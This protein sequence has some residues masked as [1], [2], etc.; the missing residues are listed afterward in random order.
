MLNR[1]TGILAKLIKRKNGRKPP[2]VR[3]RELPEQ[4]PCKGVPP[5]GCASTR[6]RAP[7]RV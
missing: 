7:F 5:R 2:A 6:A 3:R 4:P 1:R